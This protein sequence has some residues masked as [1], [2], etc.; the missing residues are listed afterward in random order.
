ML[1]VLSLCLVLLATTACGLQTDTPD[2]GGE[3]LK[4]SAIPGEKAT[5]LK[6]KFS[7]FGKYLSE[8]LGVDVE[9]VPASDYPAS[10]SMFANGDIQLAW[11]GGLTGVQARE[12]VKGAHAIAQGAEDPKYFSYFIA[13]KDSGI[14]PGD[15]FPKAMAGKKFTFGSPSSTS[16]RLMPEH[17]IRQ[18]TGKSP[19]EFFG[20]EN[21]YS[22]AHD[23]TAKNV[24][25]GAADC[26]ALS[27]KTYDKMVK[28]GEIDPK[29]ARVVWKTPYY[30][31]YNFT[32]H[33]KLETMFGEGFTEK[34]KAAILAYDDRDVLDNAFQ[35][36]KLISAKD[37]DFVAIRE[38]AQALDLLN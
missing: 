22:N 30:A 6:E 27:Y 8:K 36:S 28:K 9:Y 29:V 4:F 23:K 35:R 13:H 12:K 5:K 33:P 25:S 24:E 32:A 7:L 20:R 21:I 15:D 11:F 26:G 31:D 16:G 2:A 19:K 18:F 3:T 34:L 1:R 37:E 17:F 14:E 38:L 10:V